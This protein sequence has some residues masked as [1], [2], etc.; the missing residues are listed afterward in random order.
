MANPLAHKLHRCVS[1]TPSITDRGVFYISINERWW[2]R[3]Q[4]YAF[5]RIVRNKFLLI[6]VIAAVLCGLLVAATLSV[7]MPSADI[8]VVTEDIQP[9]DSLV[10]K[11]STST[12]SRSAVP[13]DAFTDL[14]GIDKVHSLSTMVSGDI[15]RQAHVAETIE[16][17]G[18][19]SA[20]LSGMDYS[21]MIGVALDN[22]ITAGLKINVNDKLRICA[23]SKAY[24][25]ELTP[26]EVAYLEERGI[27]P[28][29]AQ[30]FLNHKSTSG[31]TGGAAEY[32]QP[33]II[34][35]QAPV[36]YVPSLSEVEE[37]NVTVIVALTPAEFLAFSQAR[38]IGS[39]YVGVLP[40]NSDI[41]ADA[42]NPA[43]ITSPVDKAVEI[44]ESP[45]EAQE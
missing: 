9:G 28:E 34:A 7:F 13:E 20:R 25:T 39:I 11:V 41:S 4:E 27:S 31:A 14:E 29:M 42:E 5:A 10:G 19:L 22:A 8:V 16:E 18:T 2:R 6:G 36:I 30:E 44:T 24:T 45:V 35:E 15:L 32:D 38:E 26:E 17:G 21:D 43:E 40:V 3:K 33:T 37:E 12:I 1:I 23:V